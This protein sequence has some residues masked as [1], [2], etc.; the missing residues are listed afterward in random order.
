MG[1][2]AAFAGGIAGA[3][4]T[5]QTLSSLG[6]THGDPFTGDSPVVPPDSSQVGRRRLSPTTRIYEIRLVTAITRVRP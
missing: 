6:F 1:P 4:D 2:P 3:A 5:W